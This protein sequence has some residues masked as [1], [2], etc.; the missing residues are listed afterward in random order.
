[1]LMIFVSTVRIPYFLWYS[2]SPISAFGRID[3]L[4]NWI[5]LCCPF[6]ITAL[7]PS[8]KESYVSPGRP[9]IMSVY[10]STRSR[11]NLRWSSW[12]D[13][14]EMLARLT[15]FSVTGSTDCSEIVTPLFS[16][17][18]ASVF[19]TWYARSVAFFVFWTE[20]ACG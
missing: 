14:D 1:M 10:V 18:S 7:T 13:A 5:R 2:G 11:V 15:A 17:A 9:R 3:R 8:A 6:S 20:R 12:N 16:P 19:W 4:L